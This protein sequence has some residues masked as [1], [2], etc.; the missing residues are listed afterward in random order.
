MKERERAVI[1][2]LVVL[3]GILWLG[4][5]VHRSPR[6]AGSSWGGVLAVFGGLLMLVP[7]PYAFV[8][9]IKPLKKVV[10]RR[11]S[12]RTLLAW[13]IY[14]GILGPILVLLH[15]GHKFESPLGV[16]LT[17]TTLVVVVSGFVGRY[18]LGRFSQEIREKKAMLSKL[19]AAYERACAELASRPDQAAALRPFSGRVS[20]LL[21]GFFVSAPAVEPAGATSPGTLLGL[22]DSIAD[23]EYAIGT[24]E[25]FKRWFGR[26]L[27][28]HIAVS[29]LLYA[30]LGLHVWA[31]V[32]FGLRWFEP[33]VARYFS[34]PPGS[35]VR[36]SRSRA[37]DTARAV[38]RFHARFAR[39]FRAAW[40]PAVKIHGISTTVFDYRAL[41]QDA[42]ESGS[43]LSRALAALRRVRGARIGGGDREKAFWLNVYNFAA[44]KLV[45]SAYPVDS[46]RSLKISLIKNPWG[47]EAVT[48]GERGLS[49]RQIEKDVLLARFDDPRIVFGVSCAAVS[50]PDR[51][52]EIFEAKRVDEQLDAM[53]RA[54]FTNPDKGLRVDRKTGVVT[55]SWILKADKKLFEGDGGVLGFVGRYA[56]PDVAGWIRA[57]RAR[58]KIKYFEHDWSLNDAALA[59]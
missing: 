18:L 5:L 36:G 12:M 55:L 35:A 1:S 38:D 33:S 26:W 52:A 50:C 43:D 51:T 59:D 9:R 15:S 58:I 16:V 57:N 3:M 20:R 21:V 19:G 34:A 24:H 37:A 47:V 49:L 7:V 40:R 32:H 25:R 56:P 27:K 23:V 29:L 22:A 54:L 28:W 14:A 45:A 10:T 44:M 48:V 8:K 6:F 31:S 41:A 39:L 53:I 42:A 17:A 46:I 4:F 11:V 2:G 30:F 13:H